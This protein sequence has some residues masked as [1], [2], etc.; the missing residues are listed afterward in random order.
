MKVIGHHEHTVGGI[1][2]FRF[3]FL[4]G[5]QLEY[6]I[7]Y[8]PLD[9]CFSVKFIFRYNGVY[10]PVHAFCAAVPVRISR[11]DRLSACIDQGIIDAP[12]VYS[13]GNG[14]LPGFLT[15][16]HTRDDLCPELV[17]IPY[18]VSVFF[19]VPVFKPV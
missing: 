2:S 9:T 4:C 12:G 18:P 3:G 14:D 5:H 8:C 1:E 15:C 16:T 11:C 19:F 6:R 17:R 10:F 13:H 7:V